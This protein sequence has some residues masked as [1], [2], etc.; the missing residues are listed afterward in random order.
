MAI[1]RVGVTDGDPDELAQRYQSV[2]ERMRSDGGEFPPAGL[3][4][5]TAM[6]T[7]TGLRVANVWESAEAADAAWPRV[8][9]ALSEEGGNPEDMRFE[10]YEV[11]NLITA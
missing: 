4:V 9:K 11:I 6:K 2:Q 3:K 10:Q 8:Q 7:P 5:H 1:V